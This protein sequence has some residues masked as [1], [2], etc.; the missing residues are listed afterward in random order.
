MKI[1]NIPM[2]EII[3][4]YWGRRPTTSFTALPNL[5]FHNHTVLL[6]FTCIVQL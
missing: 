4:S 5:Q 1:V 3:L 2:I 6:A